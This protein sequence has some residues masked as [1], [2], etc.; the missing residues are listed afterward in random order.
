MQA[1]RPAAWRC[2]SRPSPTTGTAP[3]KRSGTPSRAAAATSAR[4]AASHMRM[5]HR[6][7]VIQIESQPGRRTVARD[8]PGGQ[9]PRTWA[10]PRARG[11][12]R[13]T[14]RRSRRPRRVG[15]TAGVSM[16]SAELS[17]V[18]RRPCRS[19]KRGQAKQVLSLLEALEDLDDV[20]SVSANFDIPEAVMAERLAEPRRP[21]AAALPPRV[22]TRVRR[23][24]SGPGTPVDRAVVRPAERSRLSSA[25]RPPSAQCGMLVG[26]APARR[27]A[28]P[29]KRQ[30]PSRTMTARRSAG[31]MTLLD[32]PTS[33]GCE[34]P[35]V[36]IRLTNRVAGKAPR[37]LGR[38]QAGV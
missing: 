20:Q 33:S 36:M 12:S 1:T 21:G 29:G 7:G 9:V 35:S 27:T 38:H 2:S 18:R 19:R 15:E 31:G 4:P 11:R 22:R 10:T 28:A 5:F 25:V 6:K 37:G 23:P 3:P 32:R 8:R 24:T 26:V 16:L 14:R 34:P 17:M 30:P 13:R